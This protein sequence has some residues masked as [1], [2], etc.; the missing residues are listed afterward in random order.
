MK[1]HRGRKGESEY[2]KVHGGTP[3]SGW[4]AGKQ[5]DEAWSAAF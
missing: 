5:R 4:L 2:R 1:K 3:F